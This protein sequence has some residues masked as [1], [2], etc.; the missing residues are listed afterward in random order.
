MFEIEKLKTYF[1]RD[2][3]QKNKLLL[4]QPEFKKKLISVKIPFLNTNIYCKGNN[5]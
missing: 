2:L 3:L 5:K 1:V 4:T